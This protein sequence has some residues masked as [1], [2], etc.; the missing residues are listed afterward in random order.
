MASAAAW[1]DKRFEI[2]I[3]RLLRVGV[4]LAAA[5][6]LA[7]GIH[8]LIQFRGDEAGLQSVSRRAR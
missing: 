4:I 2:V 7:G 3:G 5:W 1:N 8:Y 6:V